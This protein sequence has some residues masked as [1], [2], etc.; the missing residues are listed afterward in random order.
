MEQVDNEM[1]REMVAWLGRGM[2]EQGDFPQADV[3]AE[4]E[5]SEEDEAFL[6]ENGI[7]IPW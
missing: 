6:Q 1:L 4:V 5:L 7:A 3:P 2:D